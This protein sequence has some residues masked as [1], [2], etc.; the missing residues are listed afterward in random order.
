MLIKGFEKTT[1]IDY[2]G[3]IAAI[4]FTGGCNFRCDF[5]YNQALV[6]TPQQ[7]PT[8]PEEQVLEELAKRASFIDGVV[9]TG[10][11]PTLHRD[12]IPFIKQIRTLNLKIKLDTNGYQ[13][14]KVKEILAQKIVDYVAMDIKGPLSRYAEITGIPLDTKKIEQSIKLIMNAGIDY[15][16]RTT[17]WKRGFTQED[18]SQMLSLISG[19]RHYYL[20]NMFPAFAQ[21]TQQKF[22]PMLRHEVEP[23]YQ[24]AQQHVQHCALR[25]EWR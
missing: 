25:G 22:E 19:A 21:P 23:L 18:F 5:C 10:G 15:E 3:H 24:F 9:I 8:I 1:L 4:I 20:Q 7:L 6:H 2:P 12:L 14:E 11:E 16:F 17:V 13:P